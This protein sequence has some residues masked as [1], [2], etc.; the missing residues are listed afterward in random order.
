MQVDMR[1]DARGG[2]MN[3]SLGAVAAK[4]NAGRPVVLKNPGVG[5]QTHSTREPAGRRSASD[6]WLNQFKEIIQMG[7]CM[8]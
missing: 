3:S 5:R 6:S 2:E 1:D 4:C 8:K 7:V